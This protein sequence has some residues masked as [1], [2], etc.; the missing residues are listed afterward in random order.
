ME[1]RC[2]LTLKSAN[3]DICSRTI[4]H[5]KKPAPVSDRRGLLSV[6][7]LAPVLDAC[8]S[9]TKSCTGRVVG[10]VGDLLV[11]KR[12]HRKAHGFELHAGDLLVELYR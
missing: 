8:I 9:R 12:V 4:Q 5:Q 7:M 2:F 3:V 6:A 11:G 10:C 1:Y